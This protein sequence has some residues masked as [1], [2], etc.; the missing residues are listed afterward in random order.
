MFE[1]KNVQRVFHFSFPHRIEVNHTRETTKY[2]R[3]NISRKK[4]ISADF[5]ANEDKKSRS[6]IKKN[7][8][9][10]CN[11]FFCALFSA[12]LVERLFE[13]LSSQDFHIFKLIVTRLLSGFLCEGISLRL[14]NDSRETRWKLVDERSGQKPQP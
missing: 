7:I 8:S 14:T 9:K 1:E 12:V 6:L 5:F 3:R 2:L 10:I 13:Y 4:K 11:L